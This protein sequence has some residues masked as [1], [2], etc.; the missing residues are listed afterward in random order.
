MDNQDVRWIQRFSNFNKAFV[1]LDEAIQRI[2][3]EYQVDDEGSIDQ[4]DFIEDIIKEGVIQRFE[5]THELAWNV[6]KD[7]LS[8][9]G[10][11]KI[12][13]S[14]DTTKEAFA[15]GLVMD[16]EVWMDMIMSRNK[17]P[18]TYNEKTADK[19]FFK[20]ID[21]YHP[22]FSSLKDKMDMYRRGKQSDLFN[23]K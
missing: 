11:V 18:H 13:G 22:A 23:E 6:M 1:K 2:R 10:D 3:T 4:D 5:Y 14:K 7:F 21:S 8:E 20:R 16:G 19:I 12:F 15:A 17:T 9:V